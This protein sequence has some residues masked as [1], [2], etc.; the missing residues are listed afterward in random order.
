MLVDEQMIDG[1]KVV[2]VAIRGTKCQSL[3][4]WAVNGASDPVCPSDFF[5]DDANHCHAGFLKVTRAMVA[6]VASQLAA[7][8]EP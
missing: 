1:A 3:A 6:Q 8:S 5:D 2:I 4:D 7:R